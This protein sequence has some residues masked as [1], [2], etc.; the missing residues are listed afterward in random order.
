MPAEQR[1]DDAAVDAEIGGLLR[2]ARALTRRMVAHKAAGSKAAGRRRD[3]FH[4]LREAGVSI[5][6]MARS[7]G[8]TEGAVRSTLRD[9]RPPAR[10]PGAE[11]DDWVVEYRREE[12]QP[13]H[14][15]LA[16]ADRD[17]LLREARTLTRRMAAHKTKSEAKAAERRRVIAELIDLGVP[18][19]E[20]AAY[21]GVSDA[22]IH[23]TLAV[24]GAA[25]T[26]P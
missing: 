21:L 15:S 16:Q 22:A 13:V 12:G 8:V 17:A 26:G 3:V 11:T 20:V 4:Q 23:A 2:E 18:I 14:L 7:C 19:V 9:T 1:S 6:L 5:A 25:S 10:Y 24:P